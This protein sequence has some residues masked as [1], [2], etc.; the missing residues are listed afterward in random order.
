[1]LIGGRTPGEVWEKAL[2]V[3]ER[4]EEYGLKVNYNKMIWPSRSVK[5]LGYQLEGG[6][7]S[8]KKY[9]QEKKKAV[10]RLIVL[11]A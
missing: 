6:E 4:L 8:L 7:L 1:M 10:G 11:K 5:F 3:F 2:K 9:F